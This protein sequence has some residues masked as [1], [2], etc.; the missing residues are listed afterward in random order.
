MNRVHISKFADFFFLTRPMLFIP[1]WGFSAFGYFK[2]LNGT[3]AEIISFWKS[4]PLEIYIS[5]LIFS[6]SVGVVYILNQ[7]ADIEVDKKNGGL[8]LLAAGIVKTGPA[9]R[10]AIGLAILSISL[11]ILFSH[12]GLIFL[13]AA[14]IITGIL[15]S[16][17]PTFFSG[18][19]FLDFLTNAVGYGVIAFGAGWYCAG[20]DLFALSFVHASLPYFFLMC[21]GSISSTLPDI[22]GDLSDRKITTAVLL[23]KKK[24]HLLA[25]AFLISASI[26]S[27]INGDY[28][29]F[30]CSVIPLPLY[31]GYLISKTEIL[32]ESTYK[33]GGGLCV[34]VSFLA[35][36]LFFFFSG[37]VFIFTWLYFRKRHGVSYPSL[38]PIRNE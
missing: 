12:P 34:V 14:T 35:L 36:P 24:A 38:V 27:L 15:Y 32:M 10:L 21:A 7:I 17:K 1:V 26:F 29:A 3:P 4:T 13:A 5:I 8:P 2:G 11:P 33:V 31:A 9:I 18:R 28:T 30:I 25:T 37:I 19:P 20:R 22:E 6:L 16:F 23:G